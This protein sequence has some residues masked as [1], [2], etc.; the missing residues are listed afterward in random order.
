MVINGRSVTMS[1]TVAH[2][3]DSE[4]HFSRRRCYRKLANQSQ[5][6]KPLEKYF[7]LNMFRV[8]MINHTDD[9]SMHW[10]ISKDR[11]Y[12]QTTSQS[13][14][15]DENQTWSFLLLFLFWHCLFL[16]PSFYN[17]SRIR[18]LT[19]SWYRKEKEIKVLYL[20]SH[21]HKKCDEKVLS[22]QKERGKGDESS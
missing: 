4:T 20:F 3:V 5:S 7:F 13:P 1:D 8:N 16:F 6:R 14:F 17:H 21:R 15:D 12:L 2:I 11:L 9:A 22:L 18:Y 19:I 10:F